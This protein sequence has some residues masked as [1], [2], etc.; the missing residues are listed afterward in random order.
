MMR[1]VWNCRMMPR[2]A[3]NV[4]MTDRRFATSRTPKFCLNHWIDYGPV[5]SCTATSSARRAP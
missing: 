2:L 4:A 5:V 1:T 3:S